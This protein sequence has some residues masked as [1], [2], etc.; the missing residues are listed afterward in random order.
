MQARLFSYLDTQLTR[1]GGPNFTQLPINRPHCPVNDMLRDGMHQ[2]AIHT[3]QAPY[4][5]NSI[6]GGEPLVA[7]ADEGGY[8]TAP[9]RSR[10]RRC[11]PTGVVRRPLLPAGDV[12]PQPDRRRAGPHRRGVHLRTRQVLRTSHQGTQ[13]EVLA[14]VD[15][16]LCEQ[17]AIG[18]G[19]PAPKGKPPK[20]VIRLAGAFA[21]RRRTRARSPAARSESSPAPART[22]P[23]SAS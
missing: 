23:G 5:P 14:N 22:W 1:L 20:D 3:G 6:D 15:A 17:V 11:G 12:L 19:L 9:R 8:V 13:L 18:L 21:G 2:T 16:D 7:D 10:A 4:R